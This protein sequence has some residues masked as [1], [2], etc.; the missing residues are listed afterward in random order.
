MNCVNHYWQIK[1]CFFYLMYFSASASYVTYTNT[2]QRLSLFFLPSIVWNTP[3][4][5][6]FFNQMCTMLFQLSI[7]SFP[8]LCSERLMVKW[9]SQIK[10]RLK[11]FNGSTRVSICAQKTHCF[12]INTCLFNKLTDWNANIPK[13]VCVIDL[14]LCYGSL[15][16]GQPISRPKIVQLC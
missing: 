4:K 12:Q 15:N 16:L 11:K 7:M 5:I 8:F 13:S 9:L 10:K 14:I 3:K 1:C 6:N 2:I